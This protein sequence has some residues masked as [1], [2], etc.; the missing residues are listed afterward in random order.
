MSFILTLHPTHPGV[1]VLY[2]ITPVQSKKNLGNLTV[3]IWFI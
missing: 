1:F 2:D 3:Q